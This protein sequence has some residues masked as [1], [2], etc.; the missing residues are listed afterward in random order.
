MGGVVQN[1][2]GARVSPDATLGVLMQPVTDPPVHLPRT[3][4]ALRASG[5]RPRTVKAELRA[6]T[7]QALRSGEPL[8]PGIHG[9]DETVAPAVANALLA[10]HDLVLLGL[11]GQAKTRILRTLVRFL[12]EW[13]PVVPGTAL[14]ED[15]LAPL[16]PA[17]RRR[18]AA[19]GDGAEVAWLHRSQ[20]YAEKLATPDVTVA[21]LLGDVDPIKASHRGLSLDDEEV[22]TFGIIPR[23]NRGLFAINEIPDLAPRLQVVLLNL[24]EE[25]DV[26]V[27]GFPLRLPLDLAL[28]FSANPEDYTNRGNLITPLRDRIAAQILTHYPAEVDVGIKITAQEAWTERDLGARQPSVLLR[29]LVER[30]ATAARGSEFVDQSSGVS[31][32]LPIALLEAVVSNVE[33]RTLK[34]EAEAGGARLTDLFRAIPAV[35]GKL[36]LVYEGEQEGPLAVADHVIGKGVAGTVFAWLGE[37]GKDAAESKNWGPV[38]KWFADGREVTLDET[39]PESKRS[40]ALIAVPGLEALIRNGR[41]PWVGSDDPLLAMECVLEALFRKGLL[42]RQRVE[43]RATYQD[44]VRTMLEGL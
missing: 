3:L 28:L 35:C 19:A 25:R 6:N 29:E 10:Q 13:V 39:I 16:L 40:Q 30:V 2:T 18:L 11:R 20:R 7:I 12:D 26:Q 4:G 22:L 37:P 15:P 31:A 44:A 8:L 23:S 24:L 27:R 34:L 5:Y 21:D 41:K 43:G 36:E 33:R 42:A 38:L 9:Y 1:A 17:T 32:R 14:R